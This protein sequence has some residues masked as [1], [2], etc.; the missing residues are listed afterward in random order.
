LLLNFL[1][2]IQRPEY[3]QFE[4]DMLNLL[5][6]FADTFHSL[7]PLK[8]PGFA[9]AWVE[10]ISNR[11]FMAPLLLSE[12]CPDL[13]SILITD[14]LKYLQLI[15]TSDALSNPIVKDFYKGVLRVF[16]VLL[17]DFPDFLSEFS[18]L[19]I[20]DMPVGLTQLRNIVLSVFPRRIKLPYPFEDIDFENIEEFKQLPH[21]YKLFFEERITQVGLDA[22]VN[23]YLNGRSDEA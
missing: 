21:Y 7:Q 6:V 15:L 8:Y 12:E 16:L 18:Y 5:H 4:K 14:L 20:E 19:I 9:F 11:Y 3:K 1:F 17:Q 23:N 13:Y 2:D 22:D 10:L